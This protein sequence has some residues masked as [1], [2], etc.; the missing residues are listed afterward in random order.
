MV[1]VSFILRRFLFWKQWNPFNR[2]EC[3][4][5]QLKLLIFVGLWPSTDG[6]PTS[7][8][9][10]RIYGWCFRIVFMY[11]YTLSQILYFLKVDN[12]LSVAQAMFLLMTQIT[13]IWKLENFNYKIERIQK[14]L[15]KVSCVLYDPLNYAE[16]RAVS[17]SMGRIWFLV[18]LLLAMAYGTISF[19]A[20]SP[21]LKKDGN[22]PV[23]A[24]FPIDHR[25]SLAVYMLLWFYQIFGIGMSA[26]YN[27]STDTL[28]SGLIYHLQ[29]QT[30][31]LGILLS[32]M[33]SE[34]SMRISEKLPKSNENIDAECD[35]CN[36]VS[37]KRADID[38]LSKHHGQTYGC[39]V[40]LVIFHRNLL[41]FQHELID[42][43]GLSI[44]AQVIASVIIICMT[45]FL[46]TEGSNFVA[47]FSAFS[48]LITMVWQIFLYCLAGNDFTYSTD[49]LSE[50]A[51]F[52][53]YV[54]FNRTTAKAFLFFLTRIKRQSDFKVGFILPFTLSF[55]SF[56]LILKTSYS[57]FAVLNSTRK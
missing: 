42:I 52:S 33:G 44:Y 23:Q 12:L 5:L 28:A 18:T 3:F 34:N 56:I 51:M 48:Y 14:C 24:W 7:I 16:Q 20:I 53:N 4:E 38:Q 45:A 36:E 29:A 25:H 21:L 49:K 46:L 57:Y 13:L 55:S 8:I 9:G 31:R 15:R 37:S 2:L 41:G 50:R 17:N 30:K 6:T 39:L 22:L 54:C 10:Y 47:I 43:F 1:V 40:E 11:L 35:L 27:V 26:T 19:W 32:K